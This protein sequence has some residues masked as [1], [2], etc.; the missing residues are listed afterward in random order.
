M[1][2]IEEGLLVLHT[3]AK[4]AADTQQQMHPSETKKPLAHTVEAKSAG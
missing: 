3:N 1:R 2:K 4:A